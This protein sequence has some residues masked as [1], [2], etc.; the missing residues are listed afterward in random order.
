MAVL[1]VLAMA[2]LANAGTSKICS[3]KYS[4]RWPHC[5]NIMCM[6]GTLSQFREE[7]VDKC[8]GFSFTAGSTGRGSGCLKYDCAGSD[9]GRKGYGETSHDYWE[10]EDSSPKK[11][12]CV[13]KYSKKWP[14]CDNIDKHCFSGAKLSDIKTECL[15]DASCDGFSFTAGS[16]GEG[17]G[18]LKR[19]C[20]GSEEKRKGYGSGTHDYWDCSVQ[21]TLA[22]TA[23]PTAKPTIHPTKKP[24][25]KPTFEPTPSGECYL[26]GEA[27]SIIGESSSPK[28]LDLFVDSVLTLLPD[29]AAASEQPV[30]E[31]RDMYSCD[32]CEAVDSEGNQSYLKVDDGDRDFHLDNTAL[33]WRCWAMLDVNDELMCNTRVAVKV[34]ECDPE[35]VVPWEEYEE[36]FVKHRRRLAADSHEIE[37]QPASRVARRLM[38]QM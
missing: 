14:H 24:T 20:S 5:D 35:A 23:F 15:G 11:Y 31:F 9:E 25:K 8:D 27:T 10:C 7:C 34:K 36:R 21:P 19:Q 28:I 29:S 16:L 13:K 18:C 17:A 2:G 12:I 3:K 4:K 22:P 32:G 33:G 6:S 26:A 38:G 30:V 1:M 37:E